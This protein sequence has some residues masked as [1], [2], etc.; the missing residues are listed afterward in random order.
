MAWHYI[1]MG[2]VIGSTRLDAKKL[3]RQ[4]KSLLSKCNQDLEN[5]ILS[6]YTTT[7][8]DEFQGIAKS[9]RS[10]SESIF[11]VEHI[12]VQ[13]R[14]DFRLRYVAHYGE[15]ETPINRD[16]A[17]GMMGPGLTR[18]RAFLTKKGRGRS[19]FFFDFPNQELALNLTRLST[20][21]EGL[22]DRWNPQDYLLILDMIANQD[23]E[24]V[25][26]KHKKNRSQVWKRRKHLLVKEYG[27]IKAVMFD[28]IEAVEREGR[29]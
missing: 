20:V 1:L 18:A 10:V 15:I 7:L 11:H 9:L 25:A 26:R 12:R 17:Y 5:E 8:G 16:I 3:R 14:Y 21:I 13:R 28:M 19:R 6:P 29:R 4:L 24:F 23:N 2:D 22:T 27:A